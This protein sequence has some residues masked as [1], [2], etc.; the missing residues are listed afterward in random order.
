MSDNFLCIFRSCCRALASVC[1]IVLCPAAIA[2]VR[3][4]QL[5][6]Q[7]GNFPPGA[8]E[9]TDTSGE[10]YVRDSAIA[11]EKLALARRME[12]LHEWGKSADVYQEILEKYPDRVVPSGEDP[13]T[14]AVSQYVSVTETVRQ[15]LC[16]WPADGLLV[17]RSRYETEAAK[18][19]NVAGSDGVD[20]LQQVLFLYFPTDAAKTAGIRLMDIYFEEGDYVAVAQTGRRLL[21]WHPNLIA[22][23]PMVLYRTAIAQK[24]AG[25]TDD[26]RR[27][28]DELS[29]NFPQATGTIRGDDVLL[30]DSL[31][32]ELAGANLVRGEGDDSWL[33]VGGDVSRSK[34][35]TSTVRPGARLYSITLPQPTWKQI[36]DQAQRHQIEL[37]DQDQR[38][39]GSGL[40]ILPAVDR[41]QLFFQDNTRIYALDLDRVGGYVSDA[42]RH[43]HAERQSHARSAGPAI[44]RDDQR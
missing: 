23:R 33:T 14:H 35:S 43:V 16:K 15:S 6:M 20:K 29:H 22:E 41:G 1:L 38:K 10:V 32:K 42:E 7:Q 18:L 36:P 44:V 12:R 31:T 27:C 19:L 25:Q 39:R 24:L 13:Q 5:P 3:I 28:L 8:A 37:N 34:V 40:G 9:T 2:Q 21:D 4:M 11:L 17:Y 26:A 30:A